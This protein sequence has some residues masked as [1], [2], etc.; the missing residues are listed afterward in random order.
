MSCAHQG[1]VCDLILQQQIL[2]GSGTG[3]EVVNPLIE[4]ENVRIRA[5]ISETDGLADSRSTGV[6][7]LVARDL[8]SALPHLPFWQT[9]FDSSRA[10]AH[11]Q[12]VTAHFIDQSTELIS[13][14]SWGYNPPYS[15][16]ANRL[17]PRVQIVPWLQS[18]V[19]G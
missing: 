14:L 13:V 16:I 4:I 6:L 2:T 5:V 19:R 18:A 3:T 15:T 8:A 7:P 1:G 10:R 9:H 17:L 12:H 11:Y